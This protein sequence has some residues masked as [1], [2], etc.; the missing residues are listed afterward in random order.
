MLGD[1]Y[2]SQ[3]SDLLAIAIEMA[4]VTDT[5]TQVNPSDVIR[6]VFNVPSSQGPPKKHNSRKITTHRL[7]TSDECINLKLQQQAAKEAKVRQAEERKEK[8][9]ERRQRAA[10]KRAL[11]AEKRAAK[12][13]NT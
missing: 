7:L 12:N 9:A 13:K 2:Q 4:G 11:A 3:D 5:D 10:E 6:D 8:A 1:D